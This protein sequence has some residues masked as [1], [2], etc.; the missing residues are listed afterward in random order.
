MTAESVDE[1]FMR[2]CLREAERAARA[3]EVPVGAVVV[4]DGRIVARAHNLPIATHD[5]T[6]H[7]EIAV[8][9]AAGLALANYRLPDAE[10][11]VTVEPC[12]M[13]VGA[14]VQ[15]RLRRVV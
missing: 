5:P 1:R 7:A 3:G 13:C 14:I 4:R 15:A 2:V 9:R 8:L 12:I 6:A 11:Y 10:L